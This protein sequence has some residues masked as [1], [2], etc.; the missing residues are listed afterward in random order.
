MHGNE[1][2]QGHPVKIYNLPTV[3]AR[4]TVFFM[5]R[6]AKRRGLA[7]RVRRFAVETWPEDYSV[8]Q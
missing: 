3:S 8:R 5:D 4:F 1:I 2:I 7:G 6:T